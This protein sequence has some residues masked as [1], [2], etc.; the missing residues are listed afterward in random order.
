M[1]FDDKGRFRVTASEVQQVIGQYSA[2]GD[3]LEI[4]DSQGPWACTKAGEQTGTYRWKYA[5]SVLTFSKVADRCEDRVNSLTSV[6][7][8]LTS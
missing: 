7:W 8:K 1:A 4:T 2:K 6:T 5:N 3:Q